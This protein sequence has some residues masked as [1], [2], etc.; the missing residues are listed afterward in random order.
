MIQKY[1]IASAMLRVQQYTSDI[2]MFKL[3]FTKYIC[4]DMA[5]I[6]S[7]KI[8]SRLPAEEKE[9]LLFLFSDILLVFEQ[10][11]KPKKLSFAFI[12]GKNGYA[13]K[14]YYDKP[15]DVNI[16][17]KSYFYIST[18]EVV[19]FQKKVIGIKCL[20]FDS[21]E[22][23]SL[24]ILI[25]EKRGAARSTFWHDNLLSLIDEA[26]KNKDIYHINQSNSNLFF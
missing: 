20:D 18:I 5:N 1:E 25:Q 4:E 10:T 19:K 21:N 3:D 26:E 23:Y 24:D 6:K 15:N 17:F 11:K 16:A 14:V 13:K 7:T 22:E 9:C 12:Q 8:G 2:D